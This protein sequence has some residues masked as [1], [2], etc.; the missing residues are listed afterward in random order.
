MKNLIKQIINIQLSLNLI[1]MPLLSAVD[2]QV[3]GTTITTLDKARNDVPIVNISNPNNKGLSHN[4][5]IHYN[6]GEKGLILNNSKADN[7][8]TQLGGYIYGNANL[9]NEANVILNEVTSTNKSYINGYTEIAGQRADIVIANPNGLSI[10]GAGFINTNNVTLTT[11]KPNIVNETI[12]SYSIQ[13]GTIEISNG[14]LNGANLSNTDIY[15]H[16]LKLNGAINAQKLNIKLGLNKIDAT[17]KN[18]T[19]STN[20]GSVN[21]LLDSSSIGGVCMQTLYILRV[22]M[23]D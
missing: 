1:F 6:V 8:N 3:D 13:G 5:F 7:I 17:T 14:G 22:Q 15:T 11:G 23:K 20:S 21:L 9:Q 4:K 16:Y 19:S 10:N 2:L 12:G 18:I